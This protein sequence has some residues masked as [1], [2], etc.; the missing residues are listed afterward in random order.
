[1]LYKGKYYKSYEKI[2]IAYL[3]KTWLINLTL[4]SNIQRV[5]VVALI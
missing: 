5:N 3:K 2:K 4:N 1:M